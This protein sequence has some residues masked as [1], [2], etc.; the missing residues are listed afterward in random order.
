ME[1]YLNYNLILGRDILHKLGIVFNSKNKATTWQEDSISMKA[2]NS[3]AEEFFVIKES[4]PDRITTK[5]IKQYLD[6]EY[7]IINLKI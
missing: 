1:K 7:K 2:Q 3:M 4:R 5:K 6:A